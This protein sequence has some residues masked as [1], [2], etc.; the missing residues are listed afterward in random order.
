VGY[1]L[2]SDLAQTYDG[3]E[4]FW[5]SKP[6]AGTGCP[7]AGTFKLGFS[8][9]LHN[10]DAGKTRTAT[11]VPAD[12]VDD[13]NGTGYV[14]GNADLTV[15]P[16]TGGAGFLTVFKVTTDASGNARFSA[17]IPVSVDPCRLPPNA[18]QLGS[19][20][21]LDTLDGRLEAAVAAVDPNRGGIA[22]WAAHAVASADGH[23]S[24][25]RW[26]EIAPNTGALL[27][28]GAAADPSMFVWN[29]AVSPDR[30]G[31]ARTFRGNMAMSVST[32]SSTTSPAI[33]FVWKNGASAQSPLTPIVQ[34][35]GPNED[36]S[37]SPCRWG[38]YSGASADPAATGSTGKI[39]LANQ[40]DRAG[41][42]ADDTDWRTWIF[43]VSPV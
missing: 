42:T 6:A 28:S 35:A 29:G 9:F 31:S 21:K 39:W 27:Q 7:P 26:Y 23:R 1:N 2:F 20:S 30:N 37:C 3:S 11:P 4:V 16:Y 33:Q 12:L 36:F 17:P 14:V 18:P 40:Y 13:S 22:L 34:S 19:S 41:G 8:G 43:G 15:A 38:D 24:E 32:S 5:L 25:E 10:A